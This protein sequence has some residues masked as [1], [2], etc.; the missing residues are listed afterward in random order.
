MHTT[1]VAFK[2]QLM[3]RVRYRVKPYSGIL[4][5]L[6]TLAVEITLPPLTGFDASQVFSP[7][8]GNVPPAQRGGAWRFRQGPYLNACRGPRRLFHCEEEAGVRRQRTQDRVRGVVGPGPSCGGR[9]L[10]G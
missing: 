4:S 6:A 2:L 7:E 5:L 1:P 3:D 9:R 8:R 10:G